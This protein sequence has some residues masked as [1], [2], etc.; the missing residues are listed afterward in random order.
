MTTEQMQLR[1]IQLEL[2]N[3]ELKAK[4]AV[5]EQ[6]VTEALEI[7]QA[8]VNQASDLTE[9]LDQNNAVWAHAFGFE[10]AGL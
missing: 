10:Y 8:S 1:I 3:S 6:A 7:A 2:E 5:Y 9:R 4:N